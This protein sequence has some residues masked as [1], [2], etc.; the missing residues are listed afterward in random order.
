MISIFGLKTW[1]EPIAPLLETEIFPCLNRDGNNFSSL[2]RDDNCN[3]INHFVDF[4]FKKG[5]CDKENNCFERLTIQM[6]LIITKKSVDQFLRS[7]GNYK[8]YKKKNQKNQLAYI[9][10]FDCNR[11][12]KIE[13]FKE[14]EDRSRKWT[15]KEEYFICFTEL[16]KLHGSQN[17]YST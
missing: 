16:S 12:I 15:L 7:Q 5:N 2:N 1:R 14:I 4:H 6:H 10:K 11:C 17:F 3:S 8:P 9:S 13:K